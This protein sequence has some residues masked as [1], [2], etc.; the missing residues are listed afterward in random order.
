MEST[1]IYWKSPYAALEGVGIIAW[2]V[3]A[4]HVKAGSGRKTD[5][6]DAQWLASLAADKVTARR[7]QNRLMLARTHCW[8][9]KWKSLP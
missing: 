4:R 8:P 5:V 2:V 3:N 1:G 9:N 7:V 6:A